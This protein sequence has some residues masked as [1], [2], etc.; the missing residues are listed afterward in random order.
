MVGIAAC[1]G[2]DDAQSLSF[3]LEGGGKE[4]TVVGPDSAESGEAELTLVNTT[5]ND[6]E[7]QLIRVDGDHSAAETV[8]VLKAVQS[9]N[10]F[11]DWFHAGGG[12]GVIGGGEEQ[13]VTEVL[14]PGTY[15]GFN[16]EAG[17]PPPDSVPA[18]E[19]SGDE[20]EDEL[21]AD[22]TVSAFEYGFKEDGLASGETEI[23]FKNEGAQPHHLLISPLVGDATAED[24]EKAFKADAGKPPIEEEGSDDTAVIEGGETQ[25]VTL[26]LKPGRYAF[27]CFISDRQGGP[28]HALKGMVDEFE[29]E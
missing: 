8:A 27:Y 3:E 17:P 1:G 7:L 19:V 9:G 22:T 6:G 28:P 24:V 4:V 10:P 25:L 23:A 2:E 15:Y 26:D 14:E 13:T 12:V 21:S 16:L 18:M 11:P 20:V 29:I 5:D